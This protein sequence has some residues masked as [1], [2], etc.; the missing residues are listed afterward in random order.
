M[1]KFNQISICLGK[2]K[3]NN[4]LIEKEF[5]LKKNSI[6]IKTGIKKRYISSKDQTSELIALNCVKKIN[7]KFLRNITHILSVTNTPS[8]A[9]PSIAHFI[10]NLVNVKNRNI[11]CIGINSGCSGYVDALSLSHDIIKSDKKA[12]ILITTSDTYSKFIR[13]KDKYIRCL[14]SDGGSA[15]IISYSKNGWK[16]KNKFSTTLPYT[17]KFLQMSNLNKKENFIFMDGPEI[18]K[19]ALANVIPKLKQLSKNNTQTIL[20]HQAGKIVLDLVLKSIN[21]DKKLFIP[22]NFKNYGNL[23]STSIPHVFYKNYKKILSSKSIL[24][25]GFGVGLTHSYIKLE[26]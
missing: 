18:V 7:K 5:N 19:F 23:I 25:C 21:K 20:I 16:V 8:Y 17:Q 1:I 14:F 3:I 15:S 24:F 12:K 10:S 26:R 9:F 4:S 13:K 2:K 6:Y 11:N 22:T